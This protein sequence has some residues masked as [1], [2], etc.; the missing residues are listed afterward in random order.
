MLSCNVCL[1]STFSEPKYLATE[2]ALTPEAMTPET[3]AA[4]GALELP[5]TEVVML[6]T[7]IC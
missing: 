2:G 6:S 5:E 1:L 3:G 4:S 7:C